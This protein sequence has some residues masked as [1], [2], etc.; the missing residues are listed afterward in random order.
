MLL[1]ATMG[2]QQEFNATGHEVQQEFNATGH[3][4]QQGFN[5]TGHEDDVVTQRF[6]WDAVAK[7]LVGVGQ[8]LGS[9]FGH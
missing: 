6:P 4:D 9:I 1:Q 2:Q 7:G 3:E 8:V 5:A